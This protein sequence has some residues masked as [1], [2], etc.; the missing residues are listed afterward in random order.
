MSSYSDMHCHLSFM[1]NGE[2][3]AANAQQAGAY[4]FSNTVTPFEW[5]STREAYVPFTSVAV[6]FGMHP[7]WVACDGPHEQGVLPENAGTHGEGVEGIPPTPEQCLELL[8]KWQPRLIGEIGLDFGPR[9]EHTREEQ[10]AMFSAI[11]EWCGQKGD[12]LISLHTVH[13]ASEV[14]DI[15]ERSGALSTCTCLFHWYSGPSDLLKRAIDAG[16]YFSCGPRMLQTGKGRE[17]VKAIPAD[18]LLLETDWPAEPNAT[19]LFTAL[20]EELQNAAE[21]IAAIKG[22]A[23][24]ETINDTAVRLIGTDSPFRA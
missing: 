20:E 14:L 2:E 24:L 6:G 7:W 16:C 10:V 22:V 8:E 23:V 3:V 5:L 12:C 21:G 15:L 4:L 1:A 18:R 9:H 19:C 11:T 17:Y 13:A